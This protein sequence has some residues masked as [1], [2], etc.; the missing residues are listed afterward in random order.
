MS[1]QLKGLSIA[2]NQVHF[3]QSS[4]QASSSRRGG[5]SAAGRGEPI[6]TP[7]SPS[8]ADQTSRR[9]PDQRSEQA[10]LQ[11]S[12]QSE[13][14]TRVV[15]KKTMFLVKPESRGGEFPHRLTTNWKAY[16]LAFATD[17]T[18]EG[19]VKMF[20]LHGIKKL[21]MLFDQKKQ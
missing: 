16:A 8:R 5:T 1:S 2:E 3:S 4:A 6:P 19:G 7:N 13:Q 11:G 10:Q 12:E 14:P 15:P 20:D 17:D 18:L 21:R 9:V